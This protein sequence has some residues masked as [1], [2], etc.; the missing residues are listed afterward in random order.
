MVFPVELHPSV[1]IGQDLEVAVDGDPEGEQGSCFQ[2]LLYFAS[3]FPNCDLVI[4][5]ER[6]LR[7]RRALC[8]HYNL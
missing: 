6:E 5:T 3:G 7:T 1:V 4:Q 2:M 8:Y